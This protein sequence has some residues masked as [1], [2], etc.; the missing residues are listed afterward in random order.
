[1]SRTA[2]IDG[3]ILR[4]EVGYSA[5][6]AWQ[7]AGHED[8]HC[9]TDFLVSTLNNKLSSIK[10][11]AKADKAVIF[12][13]SN[14]V[15]GERFFIGE[16]KPYKGQRVPNKPFHYDNLTAMLRAYDAVEV[17]GIEADD[18]MATHHSI[19]ANTVLC[20]RDKDFKQVP[21]LLYSWELGRQPR[22][23]PDIITPEAGMK[24]FLSQMLT[25]DVADNIPGLPNVGVKYVQSIFHQNVHE[26]FS[27]VKEKYK[28]IKGVVWEEYFTEQATLLWLQR[29]PGEWWSWDVME[30]H[31]DEC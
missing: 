20:S 30:A 29:S 7:M 16:T 4:Y 12:M 18:A 28:E 13:T 5:D 14:D 3:D 23:G 9:H 15:K 11:E 31:L 27:T 22:W 8:P 21:G 25:G 10:F 1:M 24:F 6:K 2:L 17:G 26:M 19:K